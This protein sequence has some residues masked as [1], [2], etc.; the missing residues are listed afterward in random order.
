MGWLAGSYVA[1]A[2]LLGLGG[3]LELR[4]PA[5]TV[6]ALRAMGAP[7]SASVVRS[8]AAVAVVISFG[9]V[10][11]LGRPFAL[12]V[13]VAYLLLAAF[14]LAALMRHVPLQS[15]GC[16]GKEDT[17][18]TTGHLAVNLVAAVTAG[19][20]ALGPG[21]R[22]WSSVHLDANPVAVA[23]FSVLTAA[24]A[25]FAYL[26]LT[27]VPRLMTDADGTRSAVSP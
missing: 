12:A 17:P 3:A 26:A 10:A 21:G 18:P 6:G 8:G 27:A 13:S 9:A 4:R 11:G 15:C 24:V 25:A 19:A 23:L 1:A 14:V 22:G 20:V 5:A 2:V 7:A 16:F